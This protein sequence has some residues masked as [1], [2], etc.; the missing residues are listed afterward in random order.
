MFARI[1]VRSSSVIAA[2]STTTLS[3]STRTTPPA[4][5]AQADRARTR[6]TESQAHAVGIALAVHQPARRN[7]IGAHAGRGRSTPILRRHSHGGITISVQPPRSRANCGGHSRK[8]Q[9]CVR[10]AI[11]NNLSISV[12][13]TVVT[14]WVSVGVASGR[15]RQRQGRKPNIKSRTGVV[16]LL[17]CTRG[18]QRK[19]L[20][21]A[22]LVHLVYKSGD[23]CSSRE[24]GSG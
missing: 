15:A 11:A 1:A 20:K 4:A 13:V 14:Q 10:S 17:R 9:P 2:P 24:Q 6:L 7:G 5:H 8:F 16:I 12:V 19:A 22:R 3:A 18:V 21:M 23:S